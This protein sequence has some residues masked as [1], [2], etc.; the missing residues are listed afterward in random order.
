V[1]ITRTC[2]RTGLMRQRH[3]RQNFGFESII[4]AL[5]FQK[6]FAKGISIF[7]LVQAFIL[8]TIIESITCAF[9]N[10]Y[11]KTD[12]TE[13]AHQEKCVAQTLTYCDNENI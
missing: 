8:L 7:R 2:V 13:S 9:M 12:I 6:A 3:T 4:E 5:I 11:Q 10:T 1:S